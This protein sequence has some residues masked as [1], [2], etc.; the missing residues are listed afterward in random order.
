MGLSSVRISQIP[1]TRSPPNPRLPSNLRQSRSPSIDY[2]YNAFKSLL[3]V[4]SK[5]EEDRPKKYQW[6]TFPNKLPSMMSPIIPFNHQDYIELFANTEFHVL[7]GLNLWWINNQR[8][9]LPHSDQS[10]K[11]LIIVQGIYHKSMY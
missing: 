1:R 5:I 9:S 11:N 3:V 6:C 8:K 7:Q 4:L 2:I 10:F